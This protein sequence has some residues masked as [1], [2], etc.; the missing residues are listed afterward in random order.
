MPFSPLPLLF[1]VGFGWTP[2]KSGEVVLALFAGNIAIKPA[3]TSMLRRFGF[4]AVIV[5]ANLGGDGDDR[6]LR[7]DHALDLARGDTRAAGG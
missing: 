4:R 5:A 3:T 6:R 2:V 1:Q 7:A